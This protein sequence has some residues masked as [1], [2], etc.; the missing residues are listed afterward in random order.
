MHKL[1]SKNFLL[2]KPTIYDIR[3]SITQEKRLEILRRLTSVNER[4]MVK[5]GT[6]ET[7]PYKEN[8]DII[9]ADRRD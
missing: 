7:N 6:T 9:L 3:P 5:A 1:N 2:I 8:F 4:V